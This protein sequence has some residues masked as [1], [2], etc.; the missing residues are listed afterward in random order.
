VLAASA[1]AFKRAAKQDRAA[2]DELK[3]ML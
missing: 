2:A 3:E 1:R